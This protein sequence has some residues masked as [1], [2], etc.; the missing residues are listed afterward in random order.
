MIDFMWTA[1]VVRFHFRVGQTRRIRNFG[2][3]MIAPGNAA[4]PEQHK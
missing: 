3:A 1:A 2:L 4:S